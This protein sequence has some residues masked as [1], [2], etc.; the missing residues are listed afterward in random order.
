MAD[1]N[2]IV[3]SYLS[4]PG[5]HRLEIGAGSN[6]KPGWLAADIGDVANVHG[7]HAIK[8]DAS[9]PF[10]LPGERFDFIY[11][12]HMIE[13]ISFASGQLMLK[14]CYRVLK[15][16]GTIRVATPSLGFLVRIMSTDR[17]LLEQQYLEWS[18]KRFVPDAPA[19]T[20][21]F[22][23]NTFVRAWGHTFI[24]DHETLRLAMSRAGFTK[25]TEFPIGRSDQQ[26][27]SGLEN[28]GRMPPGFLALESMIF[29][30]TR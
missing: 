16:G 13:H 9:K 1:I 17:S 12:E 24:Y 11:C 5:P 18:V 3:A 6:V 10:P 2:A 19:V 26:A 21:A 4:A 28:E 15:T 29:E 30:G 22:F 23:L 7:R 14:E 27:L 20:T 25:I 8:M